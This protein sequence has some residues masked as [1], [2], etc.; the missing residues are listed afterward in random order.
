M[1][2]HGVNAKRP[3]SG[4]RLCVASSGLGHVTRGVETWAADLGHAL[5]QRGESIVLCKGQGPA[6]HPY[7]QVVSCW[8]RSSTQSKRLWSCL[9][10][11]IAWRIGMGSTYGIE[12]TTFAW[13]LIDVL[14]KKQIDVLHLQDPQ[15]AVLVQHAQRI[16]W[17]S[18]RTIMNHGTEEP[19]DF[20]QRI[21]YVQHGAPWHADQVK[22]EGIWKDSWA[23]IPNFI[24]EQRFTPGSCPEIRD[25][26]GIPQDAIVVL[27]SSAIKSRHKRVDHLIHE[28]ALARRRRPDLPLWFVIA[29]SGN[30]ATAGIIELGERLLEDRVRFLVGLP[31]A[32]MPSLYR[33]ANLLV[34]G[35]FKEMMPQ[36]LLEAI[37]SGLPCIIHQHPVMQWIVADGGVAI[38]Q[39]IDGA[40]AATVID[41]VDNDAQRKAMSLRARRQCV[42]R[43]SQDTVVDQIIE[44]YRQVG[45]TSGNQSQ[46]G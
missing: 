30:D 11:P 44:Y 39:R 29:G 28:F 14:R 35:S 38:D 34:H 4:L 8:P 10:K 42:Q 23:T 15:V 1:S 24:N 22:S 33:S 40:V 16:G 43:F 2:I 32:R 45:Q 36:A 37:G 12:Q 9:P 18:T 19:S 31:V 21:K 13:N 7:E 20:L 17:I 5:Y 41:L 25:E 27:V 6:I 26:L 46:A 3:K